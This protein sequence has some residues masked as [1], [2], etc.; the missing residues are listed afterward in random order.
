MIIYLGANV[1]SPVS[2]EAKATIQ[3]ALESKSTI[4]IEVHTLSSEYQKPTRL[5]ALQNSGITYDFIDLDDVLDYTTASDITFTVWET[6][7]SGSTEVISVNLAGNVSAP[8]TNAIQVVLEDGDLNLPTGA[9]WWELWA[10]ISSDN[11][12]VGRG[13]FM[14]QGTRNFD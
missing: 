1:V 7:A 10:I 9:Y 12:V 14:L 11:K 8:D 13:D 6:V 4:E 5:Y 3:T 2:L